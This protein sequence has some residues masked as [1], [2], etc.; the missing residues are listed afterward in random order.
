M[1]KGLGQLANLLGQAPRIREEMDKLQDGSYTIS[2]WFKPDTIPP[3]TDSANDAYYGIV[4]KN[5]CHEGLHFN[6][7]GKFAM[8]RHI[9]QEEKIPAHF[10]AK[11]LQELTRKGLLRSN[12]GPSGGFSLRVPASQIK[13]LDLVEA[14]DGQALAESLNQGPW[15]LDSWKD[16]HS[17]IMGYLE[18]NTIAD[19]VNAVEHRKA[20]EQKKL[21]AEKSKRGRR[22]SNKSSSIKKS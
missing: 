4:I 13:L 5:G 20:V 11:I 21:A 18:R 17:R 1:F 16:L 14:L 9:A 15:I 12:R 2:A 6:S 10:L 19:V 3:G 8:A 7:E 22:T